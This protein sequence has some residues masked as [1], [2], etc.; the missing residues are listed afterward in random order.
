MKWARAVW[1]A[2]TY[3]IA[4]FILLSLFS[5][6]TDPFQTAVIALIGLVFVAVKENSVT[7]SVALA[8]EFITTG[9]MLVVLGDTIGAAASEEGKQSIGYNPEGT[10][11]KLAEMEKRSARLAF[12]PPTMVAGFSLLLMFAICL[13]NLVWALNH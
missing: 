6:F 3:L 8:Q 4:I 10:A 12:S 2:F 9:R 7:F 11:A 13:Y 5:R 1:I